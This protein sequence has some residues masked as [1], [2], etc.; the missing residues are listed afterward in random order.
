MWH[1]H[2]HTQMQKWAVGG[3]AVANGLPLMFYAGLK[4]KNGNIIRKIKQRPR[5]TNENKSQRKYNF[6]EAFALAAVVVLVTVLVLV[7]AVVVFWAA[8]D[9]M[10]R[11]AVGGL[12][13][14][15]SVGGWAVD[16]SGVG[17]C[18]VTSAKK[19][20][21]VHEIQGC[22]TQHGAHL[23]PELPPFCFSS[24]LLLFLLLLFDIL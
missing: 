10:R 21:H 13:W 2:S 11:W 4:T 19:G 23:P 22:I 20:T 6:C 15:V 8:E 17:R 3:G 1:G 5:S 7:V 24:S 12:Q 16:G 18:F 9:E 14:V